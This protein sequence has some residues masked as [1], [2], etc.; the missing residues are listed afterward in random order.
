ME[1][2]FG[3]LYVVYQFW[4]T[5]TLT[6]DLVFKIIV[7]GAYLLYYLSSESQIVYVVASRDSR[8]SCTSFRVS[9]ALIYFLESSY[10]EYISIF[11]EVGILNLVY[12]CIF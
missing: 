7:S 12:G 6:F 5:V 1:C 11:F 3:W 9:V 4:V 2:I 8:M 10:Q